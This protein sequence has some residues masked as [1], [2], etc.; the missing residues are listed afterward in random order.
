MIGKVQSTAAA[1]NCAR[2]LPNPSPLVTENRIGF[3][4]A[5]AR[6]TLSMR[7]HVV[8]AR[9]VSHRHGTISRRR[10]SLRHEKPGKMPALSSGEHHYPCVANR[11]LRA[12][13]GHFQTQGASCV[14]IWP[15]QRGSRAPSKTEPMPFNS[16]PFVLFFAERL[17]CLFAVYC[18]HILL[19]V[20]TRWHGCAHMCQ[21][22]A[23]A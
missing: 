5:A 10:P 15:Q 9:G 20:S 3:H 17:D 23:L 18:E 21:H 19:L 13:A 6:M 12:C 11:P 2:A 1:C 22:G 4:G 7:R 14:D 16:M 8:C